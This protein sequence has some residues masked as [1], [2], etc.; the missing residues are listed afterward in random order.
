[1]TPV[2]HSNLDSELLRIQLKDFIRNR[3]DTVNSADMYADCMYYDSK[4][5]ESTYPWD[6]D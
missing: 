1:M 6:E 3:G 5:N 2:R 4:E